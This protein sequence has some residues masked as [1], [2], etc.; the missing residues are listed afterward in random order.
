MLRLVGKELGD[1]VLSL[2]GNVIPTRVR[3]GEFS[4]SNLLHD[5]L[6]AGAIEGRHTRQDD[7]EDDTAR[8]DVTFLVVLLV[9]DLRSNIVRSTELLIE[10][11]VSV[12]AEGGSEI[13]NLNLI[14]VFVLFK[15]DILRLQISK[16]Q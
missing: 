12:E 11:L 6:V 15:Q 7:V 2:I 14:E 5:V 16:S 13:D 8:P 10:S 1:E 4:N 9:E 3:E